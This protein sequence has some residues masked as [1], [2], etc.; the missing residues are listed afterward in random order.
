MSEIIQHLGMDEEDVKWYH[1][2]ACKNMPVN[3][4]FDDYEN[5]VETAKQT[6]QICLS[7]PVAKFCLEDALESKQKY[8]VWGGVYLSY[9]KPSKSL[10]KHKTPDVWKQ[11]RKIHGKSII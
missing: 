5:D 6:D 7:C 4:F 2:A 3:W 1:I 10:N 8:G 9:G 11:L